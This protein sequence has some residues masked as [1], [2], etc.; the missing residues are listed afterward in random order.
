MKKSIII[1]S[2]LFMVA[3]VAESCFA[4]DSGCNRG[5]DNKRGQG[6]GWNQDCP[7]YGGAAGVSNLTQE[8]KDELTALRQKFI[9][10]TYELRSGKFQKRREIKMLLQTSDP[11]RA[12]I[13]NLLQESFELHKQLRAKQIDFLLAA[14]KISPE[15]SLGEGFGK[16]HG[17][18]SKRGGKRGC[19]DRVQSGCQNQKKSGCQGQGPRNCQGQRDCQ[20]QSSG[21]TYAN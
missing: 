21:C 7:G 12:K 18:W 14:K 6:G 16:D 2:A 17:K 19:Q 3:L 8:Q 4:W 11:D 10:E 15:L 20:G 1:I 5:S 9:D 13:D